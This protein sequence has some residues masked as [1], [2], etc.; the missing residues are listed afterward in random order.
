MPGDVSP[1]FSRHE[2]DLPDA[3]AQKRGL[4][5]GAVYPAEW[6][7]SRLKPLCAALEV[8]RA[9]FG[10][11]PVRVISGYR[12]LPYN[13]ALGSKDDSQHV[14][15]R[16][17][18]FQI[19]GVCP[20]A[21]YRRVLELHQLGRIEIGGIGVYDDFNHIDVRGGAMATWDERKK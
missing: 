12:P 20:G 6:I 17:A 4:D 14:Q 2:F 19:A 16:A 13:R 15:G 8:I 3:K 11:K 1:H 21:I 18:D 7:D 5:A 10:G 9:E